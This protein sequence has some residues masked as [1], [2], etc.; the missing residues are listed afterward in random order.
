MAP[1]H[2]A[3]SRMTDSRPLL[4]PS[5]SRFCRRKEVGQIRI[6]VIYGGKE[7]RDRSEGG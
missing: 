2:Q 1:S 6:V 3:S 7:E 4:S 5:N